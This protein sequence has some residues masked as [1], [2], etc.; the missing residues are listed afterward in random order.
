MLIFS[1]RKGTVAAAKEALEV[2]EQGT[3][4]SAFTC[5]CTELCNAVISVVLGHAAPKNQKR[6][7]NM[8]CCCCLLQ[9]SFSSGCQLPPLV[10]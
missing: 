4:A 3:V 10:R 6:G 7:E 9:R 2:S 5:R 1:L 8:F